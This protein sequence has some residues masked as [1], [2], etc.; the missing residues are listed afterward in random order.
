MPKKYERTNFV[1]PPPVVAKAGT[2]RQ[3]ARRHA[4]QR[5]N[6]TSNLNTKM[7]MNK[8]LIL[9]LI[10]LGLVCATRAFA[11]DTIVVVESRTA[12]DATNTPAWTVISGDWSKSKNKT[13]VDDMTAFAAKNVLIT[14]TNKP[15]PAFKI[16][17][18]GLESGKTY[19]VDVTFGTS[20][21]QHAAADL[22]VAVATAG[23]SASTIPTNTPV[24]QEPN[25]SSWNTLGTITPNTT[26]PT[27]TF[28]YKS[29]TLSPTSR[30]YADTFRFLPE[31]AAEPKAKEKPAKKSK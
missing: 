7:T 19:R 26:H 27:L 2:D 1:P 8:K 31:G 5:K 28:T 17:P 6:Q 15:V 10:T 18:Q 4:R 23:V 13:K 29:G 30:W 22:V 25:A 11:A 24:F 3:L 16:S 21:S 12:D 14:E 20:H 9:T